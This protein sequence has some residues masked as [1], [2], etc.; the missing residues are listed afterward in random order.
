MEGIS[1][2]EDEPDIFYD[3]Y[4]EEYDKSLQDIAANFYQH[5]ADGKCFAHHDHNAG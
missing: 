5:Q 3:C 4:D 2:G 1:A